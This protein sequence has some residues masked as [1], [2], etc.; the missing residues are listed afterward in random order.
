MRLVRALVASNGR[1]I[2]GIAGA[3]GN[4]SPTGS[5]ELLFI[6]GGD[7]FTEHTDVLDGGNAA[8]GER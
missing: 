7:A 3:V 1:A 2:M 4:N 6:D 8:V 5:T